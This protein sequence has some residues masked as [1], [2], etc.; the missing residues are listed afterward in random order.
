MI[1]QL[2]IRLFS[3]HKQLIESIIYS[4]CVEGS[5]PTKYINSL[6]CS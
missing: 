5:P 3:Q 2:I 6:K 4:H 1:L